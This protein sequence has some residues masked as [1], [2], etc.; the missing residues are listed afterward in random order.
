MSNYTTNQFD[1]PKIIGAILYIIGSFV[2]PVFGILLSIILLRK[3]KAKKFPSWVKGIVIIAIIYQIVLIIL[4]VLGGVFFVSLQ[5][6]VEITT[7]VQSI[8]IE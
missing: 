2:I 1:S 7:E 5:D 4:A 8:L 6:N 3:A